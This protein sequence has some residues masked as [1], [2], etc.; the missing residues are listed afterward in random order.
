MARFLIVDDSKIARNFLRTVLEEAG[1]EI[2]AE[3]SNGLEGF[4]MFVLHNPDVAT[5]D[6]T[7]PIVGGIDCLKNIIAKFPDAKTIIVSSVGKDSVIAEALKI[8]AKHVLRKPFEKETAL[9]VID[10]VLDK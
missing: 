4:D 1:H 10:A 3:A 8:G 6:L 9:K 7:M 5:I 2:V